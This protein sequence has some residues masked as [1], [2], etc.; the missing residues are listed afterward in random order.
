MLF[1]AGGRAFC[2]SVTVVVII[3]IYIYIYIYILRLYFL[4][5]L[6]TLNYAEC[7]YCCISANT[8]LR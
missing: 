1:G 2:E 7:Y 6:V 4:R 5:L 8:T 3:N